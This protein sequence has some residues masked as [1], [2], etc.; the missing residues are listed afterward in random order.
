MLGGEQIY[1]GIRHAARGVEV[2][3]VSKIGNNNVFDRVGHFDVENTLGVVA[4]RGGSVL[5]HHIASYHAM[6]EH[7]GYKDY[8]RQP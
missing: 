3:S 1:C 7:H 4:A 5:W 8:Q 6:G 2:D